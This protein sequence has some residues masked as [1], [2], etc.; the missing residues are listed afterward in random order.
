MEPVEV[1]R[2]LWERIEARDWPGMA[3]LLHPD[4]VVD[5][6]VTGETFRGADAFV[7]IQREY[8]EGWSI[9][10]IRLVA[11]GPTVVSE[12]EVPQIAV[13][14]FRAVSIWQ[15]ENDQIISGVEYWS[16]PGSEEPPKWRRRYSS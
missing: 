9:H 3:G 10:P 1:V 4:L 7:S 5:W 8:P 12:I 14:V 11:D 16:T 13:G 6:P 2:E 15:V